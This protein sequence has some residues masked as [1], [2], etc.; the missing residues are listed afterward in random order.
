[1]SDMGVDDIGPHIR[2]EGRAEGVKEFAERIKA[3]LTT[4]RLPE[5]GFCDKSDWCD[6]CAHN[7]ALNTALELIDDESRR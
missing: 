7:R 3:R 2:A 4:L 1:M 5:R 6:H